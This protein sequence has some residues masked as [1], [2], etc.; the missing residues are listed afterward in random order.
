MNMAETKII[1]TLDKNPSDYKLLRYLYLYRVLDSKQIVPI[2]YKVSD[3]RLIN[4]I[5]IRLKRGGFI[6]TSKLDL[7]HHQLLYITNKG[8]TAVKLKYELLTEIWDERTQTYHPGYHTAAEL[9]VKKRFLDHQI[10]LNQFMLNF[11]K[12]NASNYHVNWR[13][14]DEAFISSYQTIRP[15]ALL[16]VLNNDYLIELDMAT[17]TKQQLVEKWQRYARFLKSAEFSMHNRQ[18]IVLF[19]C[20]NLTKDIKIK[21]RIELVRHTI[22]E[23]L[24]EVMPSNFEIIVNCP[25][26]ILK[27]VDKQISTLM[28]TSK[29]LTRTILENI[30][31]NWI[32]TLPNEKIEEKL[33]KTFDYQLTLLNMNKVA[34]VPLT[35]RSQIFMVDDATDRQLSTYSKVKL[36]NKSFSYLEKKSIP[37]YLVI[38]KDIDQ[39]YWDYYDVLDTKNVFF[40]TLKRLKKFPLYKAIF[41]Y[42]WDGRVTHFDDYSWKNIIWEPGYDPRGSNVIRYKVKNQK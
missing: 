32:L 34:K 17:E 11:Q 8:I 29:P 39:G 40:T 12:H 9:K 19:V 4:N 2:I 16:Q 10:H 5:V 1:Q 37:F 36:F 15:D 33:N 7:P 22:K 3:E 35:E 27:Y 20:D 21:R 41:R 31:D 30:G 42:Q 25:D 13:Y 38:I 18:I 23:V 6:T 28:S 14:Y 26:V 24:S